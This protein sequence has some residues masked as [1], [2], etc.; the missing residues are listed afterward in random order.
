MEIDGFST[1]TE[2][3]SIWNYRAWLKSFAGSDQDYYFNTA[4]SKLKWSHGRR[5]T[6]KVTPSCFCVGKVL[7]AMRYLFEKV[8]LIAF[9]GNGQNAFCNV[10][11]CIRISFEVIRSREMMARRLFK[12]NSKQKSRVVYLILYYTRPG[13]GRI[14]SMHSAAADS[15]RVEY[16]LVVIRNYDR[17]KRHLKTRIIL[18]LVP[19]ES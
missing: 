8:N 16:T 18:Q 6:A 17:F 9:N 1:A 13:F 5:V 14:V 2:I 11:V 15:F 7:V 12:H 19:Y 3:F 10:I 4:W